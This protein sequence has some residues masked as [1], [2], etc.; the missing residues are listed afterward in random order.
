MFEYF[1]M[2]VD[3]HTN[4]KV[5]DE[6]AVQPCP[7]AQQRMKKFVHVSC[8]IADLRNRPHAS[9][10]ISKVYGILDGMYV[11]QVWGKEYLQEGSEFKNKVQKRHLHALRRFLSEK[12]AA[13]NWQ[14]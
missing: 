2:L 9:L 4:L 10:W 12:S 6:H 11:C 5:P 8:H 13:T 14:Y 1:G 3:K 7:D